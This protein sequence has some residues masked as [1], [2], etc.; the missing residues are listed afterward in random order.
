MMKVKLIE[1]RDE[2]TMIVALCVD[3]NPA[4]DVQRAYLRRYG[5]SCDGRPN[6]VVTHADGNG[7][8]ATNDPYDWGGRT[9]PVAHHYIIDHWNEL[10]D[11]SV[12]DVQFILGET[13]APKISE[14]L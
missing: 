11:G 5:Y 4:N 6:I 1:I 10:A 2:A 3:M 12:V 14:L 13:K 7:T 9:W 8:K